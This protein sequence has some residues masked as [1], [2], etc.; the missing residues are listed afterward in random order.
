MRPSVPKSVSANGASGEDD[1]RGERAADELELE[2]APEEA[3]Q[4]PPVLG[5]DVAEAELRE[6][7]L[8]GEVEERLRE[9]DDRHHRREAPEVREAE[10][11]GGGDRAEDAEGDR[12]VEPG[13]GRR[14]AP[15]SARSHRGES[16]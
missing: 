5:G 10:H 9:A 3:V 6:A 8:D 12:E 15:E 16:V 11:P 2:R 13:C 4:L 14:P 1:E 7:L